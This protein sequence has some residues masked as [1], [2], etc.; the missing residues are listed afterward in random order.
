MQ[1]PALPPN[2]SE[3]LAAVRR[4]GLLDTPPEER[5]DRYTRLVKR[6]FGVPIALVTLLDEKR[7][8]FKA[9]HGDRD[10]NLPREITFCGHTILGSD[11]MIVED[12]TQDARFVGNPMV[13]ADPN[14]R[15]YAG[16]PLPDAQGYRLGTLC[17]LDN[18]PRTMQPDDLEALRDI[19]TMVASELGSLEL[20]TTDA[21]TGLSN[22][23]GFELLARQAIAQAERQNEPCMVVGIDMDGFK[24]INDTLGH[25]VGDE[26]LCSFAQSMLSTFRDSD[27]IA[28]TGGDEFTVLLTQ[29]TPPEAYQAIARL[30]AEL[31][32]KN[33]ASTARFHLRFSS[34]VA[35]V[36]TTLDEALR[37]ADENMYA[38]KRSKPPGP[39]RII[40][41]G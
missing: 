9:G 30:G 36:L 33:S 31:D 26:A 24:G 35:P 22:R 34:G 39:R 3:R 37:K 32:L 6:L 21:L 17:I 28:R 19:G 14:I 1:P 25:E 8:F 41:V 16:Y 11:I 5:F 29:T 38:Q 2:E 20:A 23:R 10:P 13:V 4:L 40:P 7:Q 18:K 12:A 27:V 15:F